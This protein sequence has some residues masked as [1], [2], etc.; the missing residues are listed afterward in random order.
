MNFQLAVITNNIFL[1][2]VRKLTDCLCTI[3]GLL[4]ALTLFILALVLMDTSTY[5]FYLGNYLK[6][7]YPTDSDGN[8]C[9]Y[10]DNWKYPFIFFPDI[11]RI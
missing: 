3:I 6:S 4:F 10:G 9:S 8:P 11:N 7:N 2:E 1:V 5:H